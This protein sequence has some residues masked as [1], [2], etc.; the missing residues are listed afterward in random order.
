VAILEIKIQNEIIDLYDE[1][2]IVQSFSLINIEDITKR[3]S[4]YS[5]QF[6]IPKTNRNLQILGYT[7]FLNVDTLLPY[8]RLNCE[9]LIDGFIFKKGFVSIE[10]INDN[11][12]LQFFTGNAGF[13]EILKNKNINQI[14]LVNNPN[15]KTLWNLSNVISL[16]NASEGIFFPMIDYNGMPTNSTTVDVRL[17]LPSFFRKTLMQAICEDAGYTLLNNIE[18]SIE[19]YNNDILPTSKNDLKN[20]QE[21]IDL[22]TYKGADNYQRRMTAYESTGQPTT[23]QTFFSLTYRNNPGNSGTTINQFYFRDLIAGNPIRYSNIPSGNNYYTAGVSGV[24]IVSLDLNINYTHNII[25]KNGQNESIND[26][27]AFAVNNKIAWVIKV[28]NDLVQ[29]HETNDFYSNNSVI[30]GQNGIINITFTDIVNITQEFTL[31][32]GDQVSLEAYVISY[33]SGSDANP[34]GANFLGSRVISNFQ[35]RTSIGDTFEVKL[36]EGLAFGGIVSTN[37]CLTDIKQSDFFK[38]TCIRYCLVPII[39]EDNKKVTLFEFSEIKRNIQNAVDWSGKLD[40]TNDY[41]IEFKIDTYGQRNNIK[42]KEDNF[43]LTVPNGSNGVI[44]INNQNL[45]LEKDLYESPFAPSETVKRLNNRKV[46]Y[47]DL[48][49]G[50][51]LIDTASFKNGVEA[52]TCYQYKDNFTV[53]YTDGIT[54]T[55]VSSNIPMTWFIDASKSYS[56]GFGTNQLDYSVDLIAILQQLKIV[57]ADIRLNILDIINL[58]YFYPIYISELNSYF[59]LSKIN[60]F[61]YTSNESTRVELIKIN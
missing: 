17:L 35:A 6:E 5:N 50:V 24:H 56:A 48:H 4:E 57:K 22:N 12:S 42:H 36:G 31:E 59:F 29:V 34:N 32:I 25:W 10:I 55:I 15:L 53:T 41:S 14:N 38:D 19:A 7:D 40:Q 58:N 21:T 23:L 16:R 2:K 61:D 9:I 26:I 27:P 13:Y 18:T 49:D 20:D 28:N 60:Q 51:S 11:I 52:R 47:I 3:E 44:L 45:E 33:F 54:N 30:S 43:V 1:E 39:D 46:V 37:N 8:Q